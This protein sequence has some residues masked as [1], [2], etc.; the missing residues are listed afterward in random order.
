MRTGHKIRPVCIFYDMT[1]CDLRR[2]DCA[3]VLNVTAPEQ[4][5]ARLSALNLRK[6]A[7]FALIK[8]SFRK[9]VFLV[10][11]GSLIAIRREAA[12]WIQVRKISRFY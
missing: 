5:K 11:A 10:R 3:E 4:I 1:L 8:V 6:G 7:R 12:E 2:G 9:S